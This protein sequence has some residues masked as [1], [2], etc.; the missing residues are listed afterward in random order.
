MLAVRPFDALPPPYRSASRSRGAREPQPVAAMIFGRAET[1]LFVY[2][3][4]KIRIAVEV[5]QDGE[6]LVGSVAIGVRSPF[7]VGAEHA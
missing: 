4:I 1:R 7:Q 3:V 2:A 5:V 6:E